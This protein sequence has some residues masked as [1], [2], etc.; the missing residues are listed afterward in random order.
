MSHGFQFLSLSVVLL[1]AMFPANTAHGQSLQPA[2]PASTDTTTRIASLE[3][4]AIIDSA[5]DAPFKLT[6]RFHLQARTNEGYLVVQC[7]LPAG[8]HIYS[9]TQS[10]SL[11]PTKIQVEPSNDFLI[12][13]KFHPDRP[14]QVVEQDPV[15][16]QRIEKHSGIIRFFVPIEIQ[17]GVDV[18][19]L[20]PTLTVNGLVCSADGF[21]MP[22]RNETVN[23]EFSGYFDRSS[24]RTEN[25]DDTQ[26]R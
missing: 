7:E 10:G 13:G 16:Q 26:M 20:K 23:A 17:P 11:K 21:C 6:G 15:L 25:Q 22:I 3:T 19:Q 4:S 12:R 1:V 8:N 2:T 14:P 24:Q 5:N 9:L 18:T